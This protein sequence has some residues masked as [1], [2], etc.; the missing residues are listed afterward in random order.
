MNLESKG[1]LSHDSL[2]SS[3]DSNQVPLEYKSVALVSIKRS[4]R[5]FW[6][7]R[8]LAAVRRCCAEWGGDCYAK[9]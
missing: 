6:K 7:V 9:L 8:G 5:V 1:D 2:C 4:T 3:R